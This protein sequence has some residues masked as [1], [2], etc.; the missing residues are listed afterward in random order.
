[1]LPWN[2]NDLWIIRFE[3]LSPFYAIAQLG[4]ARAHAREKRGV[5]PPGV[6]EISC[7]WADAIDIPMLLEGSKRQPVRICRQ[8]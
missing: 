8:G 7:D 3:L 4:L 5:K 1:M 2:F 6:Q